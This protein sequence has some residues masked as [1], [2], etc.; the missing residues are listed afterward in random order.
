MLNIFSCLTGHTLSSAVGLWDQGSLSTALGKGNNTKGDWEESGIPAYVGILSSRERVKC[1]IQFSLILKA[2]SN[3]S[4]LFQVWTSHC[5]EDTN[6][7]ARE[8]FAEAGSSH[9]SA[10]A[11]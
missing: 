2:L 4:Y 10:A 7:W 8:G 11:R 1:R 3:A 5:L 9:Q 6:R